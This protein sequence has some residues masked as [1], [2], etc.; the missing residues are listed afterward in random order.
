M[1]EVAILFENYLWRGNRATKHSADHFD[2][3]KS[4]NYPELAKIGLGINYNTDALWHCEPTGPIRVHTHLD[5]SVICLDLFPGIRRDIVEYI[6]AAPGIKG[7]VLRT[8]GAGNGLTEEWFINALRRAIERGVVIV[9]V[10]QCSNGCVQQE[11]YMTGLGLSKA[12]VVSG[13]DL[14]TEAA[15][16]KLMY[17]LGQGLTGSQVAHYMQHS[18]RG[19]MTA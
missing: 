1:C 7:V 16:T 17:L 8:Y 10:T 4:N 5:A 12:G 9:N 18:L 6:L 11:R 15:L 19:E 3:F 13:H 14:T 2:A